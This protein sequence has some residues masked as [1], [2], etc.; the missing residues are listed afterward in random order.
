MPAEANYRRLIEFSKSEELSEWSE[1]VDALIRESLEAKH[2]RSIVLAAR[3]SRKRSPLEFTH[4]LLAAYE[5]LLE[6]PVK[7]DPGCEG[8]T[9]IVEALESA[10]YD[11]EDFFLA[12]ITYRQIEPAYGGSVDK[13]AKLRV[14]AG[15]ALTELNRLQAIG[16]LVEL[17]VD[18]EN[19]A[20]AGAARALAT[21]A[22]SS[23]K[24]ILRLKVHMGD[25]DPAVLGECCYALLAIAGPTAIPV[26]AEHFKDE[27]RD[28]RM[29]A[30]FALGN[31]RLPAAL[32]S[33]RSRAERVDE[34]EEAQIVLTSIAL[35][36]TKEA[37]EYLFS[38][39]E[40]PDPSNPFGPE[41]IKALGSVRDRDSIRLRIQTALEKHS[42]DSLLKAFR[43]TFET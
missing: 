34:W 40:K 6:D 13:A 35:L 12:A 11:N 31:S 43:E 5:R 24:H 36:Q 3:L 1:E 25:P 16:P 21:C 26:V 38:I 2:C 19:T 33:L 41:S 23:A 42:N 14:H 29:E 18:P 39:I 10:R 22:E 20:R 37:T 30:A 17:L 28:V 32:P 15:F 27:S 4:E 8:K 7:N 9:A